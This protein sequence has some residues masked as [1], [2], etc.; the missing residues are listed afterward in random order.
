M[1][2]DSDVVALY[3]NGIQVASGEEESGLLSNAVSVMIGA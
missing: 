3:V 1:L 2:A